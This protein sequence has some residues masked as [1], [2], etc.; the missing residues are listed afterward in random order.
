LKEPYDAYPNIG[1]VLPAMGYNPEQ[2]KDLKESI[3]AVECDAVLIATPIDLTR[4]M[5]ID[6]PTARVRYELQEI[7]QP[8]LR[9]VL[10]DFLAKLE[11]KRDRD[12][13]RK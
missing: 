10:I 12:H 8:D 6:K 11:Q 1:P 3:A 13:T 5:K 9:Q 7:G 4:I 2:V